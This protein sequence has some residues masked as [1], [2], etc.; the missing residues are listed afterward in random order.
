M[1]RAA[2]PGAARAFRA[3]DPTTGEALEP[4]FA[5]TTPGELRELGR[6][7]RAAFRRYARLPGH[8]RAAFLR[9]VADGL[10]A[11]ADELV[12]RATR[13]TA[14]PEARLRGEVSRTSGQLRMFAGLI[15]DDAWLGARVDPGDPARQPAPK[16]DV[17]AVRRPLGPV[18]VFGASNF[19]FAFSVAGGDTAAALAAGCPVIAKAHPGHPGTSRLVADVVLAAAERTGMPAGV[20]ALALDDG[21]AVG[22]ALVQLPEVKAVAFTGSRAGGEALMRLAAARPEPVPVYAE[23][24]SVNP[25]FVLPEAA[26]RRGDAIAEDLH[27]SFTLGVGQFCTNPGVVLLP[28]GAAGDA[29]AARLAELTRAGQAGTMLNARVCELYQQGRERLRAAGAELLAEGAASAG[30]TA[31]TPTL[32]QAPLDAAMARPELLTEVFGPSTLLLR[33]ARAEQLLAFADA[34]EGQLTATLQA[35][36]EEL[37]AQA[38]LVEAL[39]DR[40]GRLIVNQFP[41]GVEV[42][43]A[44]VHGGPWPATSDGRGTSVGTLAIDRFTRWVAYQNFPRELLPPALRG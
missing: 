44:M 12:A 1:T 19:P 37:P 9:A 16:P 18:A 30:P 32:W 2:E 5:V 33:Y 22:A 25:V 38:E 14:L 36:A 28:T 21:H 13:E 3:V 42:G 41:T 29:L 4:A 6:R 7:A 26:R 31:G 8:E 40:A 34:L 35:E 11:A 15:E 20:F 23:M 27:A 17:R 10:D 39:A 43:P 24:G